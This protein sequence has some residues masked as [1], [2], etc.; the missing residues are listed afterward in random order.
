[1]AI[2]RVSAAIAFSER[3]A[4]DGE[5]GDAGG[6][7]QPGTTVL[8]E[9]EAVTM[10]AALSPSWWE[11]GS[12]T[13]DEFVDMEYVCDKA[14]VAKMPD[15]ET[16]VSMSAWPSSSD[17]YA[18]G[19]EERSTGDELR[20]LPSK[21]ANVEGPVSI[22]GMSTSIML[23][24][25]ALFLCAGATGSEDASPTMNRSSSSSDCSVTAS[26]TCGVP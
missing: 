19:F 17:E 5:C 22:S 7:V 10:G 21:P 16:S 24:D 13:S 20:S 26:V 1:M 14:G 15:E 4:V 9:F 23:M 12:D 8:E 25:S 11:S 6:V 3:E 18:D 2:A